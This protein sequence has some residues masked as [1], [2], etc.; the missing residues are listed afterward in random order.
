M[1]KEPEKRTPEEQAE[2]IVGKA[3][4]MAKRGEEGEVPVYIDL[5]SDHPVLAPRFHD[6]GIPSDRNL[7]I[8]VDK[9]V[10]ADEA[11]AT[12]NS[13]FNSESHPKYLQDVVGTNIPGV[14]SLF[15]IATL[16]MRTLGFRGSLLVSKTDLREFQKWSPF[17]EKVI[18]RQR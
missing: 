15:E 1:S 3:R 5:V 18:K 14:Y 8:L 12:Y 10:E 17:F 7:G 11:V 16:P 13:G 9:M 2:A 6:E 4:R